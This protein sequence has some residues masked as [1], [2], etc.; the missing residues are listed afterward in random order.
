MSRSARVGRPQNEQVRLV[1]HGWTERNA[2]EPSGEHEKG[3]QACCG[4]YAF[5][6]DLVINGGASHKPHDS[7][8]LPSRTAGSSG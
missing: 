5:G 8:P 2:G 6:H 3:R 7:P 4:P 1:K